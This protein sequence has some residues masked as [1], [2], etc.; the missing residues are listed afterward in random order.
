MDFIVQFKVI[1]AP[2]LQ[3]YLS[4]YLPLQVIFTLSYIFMLD[5]ASF[6]STWRI[7][8]HTFLQGRFSGDELAKSGKVFIL[9]SLLK[10]CF[11]VYGILG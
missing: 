7:F 2:A 11:A 10:D 6:V 3:Y 9:P 1:Y 8:F 4:I 5:L